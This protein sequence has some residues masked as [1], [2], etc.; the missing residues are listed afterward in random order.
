MFKSV[1]KAVYNVWGV[2]LS[3]QNWCVNIPL[4]GYV[5]YPIDCLQQLVAQINS[6]VYKKRKTG[7]GSRKLLQRLMALL[8]GTGKNISQ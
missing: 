6:P 7:T 5:I 3:L 4:Q 2:Q 8:L 1:Q